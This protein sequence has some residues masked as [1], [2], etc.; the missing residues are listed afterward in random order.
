MPLPVSIAAAIA[1]IWIAAAVIVTLLAVERTRAARAAAAEAELLGAMLAA[2]PVVPMIAYADGRIAMGARTGAWLGLETVPTSLDALAGAG[3]TNAQCAALRAGVDGI[4]LS[5][6]PLTLTLP[7]PGS[8]RRLSIV[9]G[10][11]LLAGRGEAA[12]LLWIGDVTDAQAE[13]DRVTGERDRLESALDEISDLIEA[14]PFPI[15]YRAAGRRLARVNTSYVRAV[16]GRDAADVLRRGLELIEHD[17]DRP[18][19]AGGFGT[20]LVPAIFAGQRRMI[21]LI[22]AS[23]PGGGVAGFATDAQEL[24][25]ARADLVRFVE[26]QQAAFDRLSAAVARFAADRTL[27]FHNLRFRRM[28]ALDAVLLDD[29]PEFDRIL[30]CMRAAER[31]PESRDFRA[32][33]ADRRAWFTSAGVVDESWALPGGTHLRVI[34]QP[35]PDGGLLVIFEDRTER[36]HLASARDT[37]LRVRATTFDT[38]FE[39][40]GVFSA[41]GRLYLWNGHFREMWGLEEEV[42]AS[43]PHLDTLV[44]AITLTLVEPEQAAQIREVVRVVT[45]DR[46]RRSGTTVLRNGRRLCFAAVPLPDGNALFT[47][48]DDPSPAGG[49]G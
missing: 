17:E 21:R 49:D 30:E 9:G 43:H 41:D 26:A 27:I 29:R 37:L 25:D 31:A 13:I 8:E 48:I 20:D 16:E 6:R 22:E 1:L 34:A 5:A 47:L 46:E 36:L 4:L 28:F 7:L 32:W 11:L 39:A 45:V 10:P 23:M 40:V 12:A 38:L 15:W 42:L 3:F 19:V 24:A 33:R 14:A 2:A 35:L 44:R 18:T